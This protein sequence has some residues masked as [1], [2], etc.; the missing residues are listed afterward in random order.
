MA[1][2]SRVKLFQRKLI[3]VWIDQVVNLNVSVSLTDGKNSPYR[4]VFWERDARISVFRKMVLYLIKILPSIHDDGLV[5]YQPIFNA[6]RVSHWL[7]I[8]TGRNS[9]LHRALISEG[10]ENRSMGGPTR[11]SMPWS[12]DAAAEVGG[13]AR[14]FS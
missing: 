4:K 13:V 7:P 11:L 14:R 2:Y 9:R 3:Q 8:L 10:P 12:S 6:G 5:V 1:Y